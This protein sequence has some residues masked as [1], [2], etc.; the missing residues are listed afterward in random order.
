MHR[1]LLGL[2]MGQQGTNAPTVLRVF[3]ST[4]LSEA[5]CSP[6][7]FSFPNTG[8]IQGDSI[9][10][11]QVFSLRML[12]TCFDGTFLGMESEH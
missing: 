10:Q 7:A 4:S 1:T 8:L 3:L 9:W 11:A 2:G 5:Q 6:R 12:H